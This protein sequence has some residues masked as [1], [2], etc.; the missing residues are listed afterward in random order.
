M[1]ITRKLHRRPSKGA[2]LRVVYRVRGRAWQVCEGT[3]QDFESTRARARD[4][5][6]GATAARVACVQERVKRDGVLSWRE[7]YTVKDWGA[8]RGAG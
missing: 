5:V 3:G 4:L 1:S 7:L 8:R 2:T 6:K